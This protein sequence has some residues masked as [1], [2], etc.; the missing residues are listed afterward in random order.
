MHA[1]ATQ[2]SRGE[3]QRVVDEIVRHVHPQRVVLFGSYAYGTPTPDSD[4]DML[5][6]ME[7]SLSNV[8]QAVEIRRR[9][10]IPFPTDLLVRT[11]KQLAE[12]LGMGDLL[13][14][15]VM[16]KGVVLYEADHVGM[17]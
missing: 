5:V 17:G 7:T 8:E 14:K 13:F 1:P 4:V 9:V 6:L 2:V 16:S 11:P 12:R 15:E 3:I 10:D